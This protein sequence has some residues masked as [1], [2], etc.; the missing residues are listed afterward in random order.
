MNPF[1]R[2]KNERRME[3][4]L[5]GRGLLTVCFLVG[6]LE[7]LTGLAHTIC[8]LNYGEVIKDGPTRDVCNDARVQEVYLCGGQVNA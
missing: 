4:L 8:V 2:A 5:A 6:F 1:L 3:C 7:V